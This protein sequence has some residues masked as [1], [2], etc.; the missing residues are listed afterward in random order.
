MSDTVATPDAPAPEPMKGFG[1]KSLLRAAAIAA[2]V[3]TVVILILAG[4]IPP[5]IVFIVLWLVGLWLLRRPGKAGPIFMLVV[6]IAYLVTN[7][8]FSLPQLAVPASTVDFVIALGS[9]LAGL[10]AIISAIGT[11]A[12]RDDGPSGVAR[13]LGGVV[14][15]LFVVGVALSLFQNASFENAELQEG[16]VELTTVDI[17]FSPAEIEA[18]SGGAVFI[19]NDDPVLHT[20]TIDDLDIDEDIPAGKTV[21]VVIDAEPGEYRFYCVPHAPDMEG[22]LTVR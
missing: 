19:T 16:D 21:R 4:L 14:V 18:G 3:V 9:W 8:P 5:L 12:K 17:E 6:F 13:A 15:G 10:T 2:I 22:Q 20:F 1:W 11:L 7:A